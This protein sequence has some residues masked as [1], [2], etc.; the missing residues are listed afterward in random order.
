MDGHNHKKKKRKKERKKKKGKQYGVYSKKLKMELPFDPAIPPLG[1]DPKNPETP[2]WKNIHTPVFIA[3]FT[4]FCS[5]EQIVRWK[6]VNLELWNVLF[7]S[8]LLKRANNFL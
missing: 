3:E 7:D 6:T 4:H 1:I 5:E 2:I 8:I